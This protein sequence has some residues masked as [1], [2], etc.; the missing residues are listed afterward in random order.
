MELLTDIVIVLVFVSPI[1]SVMTFIF[2]KNGCNSKGNPLYCF[3]PIT[4]V[5]EY[6]TYVKNVEDIVQSTQ[7]PS[8]DINSHFCWYL[9]FLFLHRTFSFGRLLGQVYYAN[10]AIF[11]I[12]IWIIYMLKCLYSQIMYFWQT[13]GLISQSYFIF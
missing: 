6:I 7:F 11:K 4:F 3:F 10:F 8:N 2:S 13:I 1:S 12:F 5:W 9:I